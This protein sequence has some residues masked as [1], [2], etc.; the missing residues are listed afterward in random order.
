L[1]GILS[2]EYF[3]K[4]LMIIALNIFTGSLFPLFGQISPGDLTTAH[5]KLEGISNCT[6]C[7]V[8]GEKV[9]NSKCLDCHS[10]I[11]DLMEKGKGFHSGSD[12]K[13]KDCFKC[14]SE[15]NGREFRII[16]FDPKGFDHNKTGYSL[17]GK[18]AEIDCN[19]CHQPKFVSNLN[20]KRIKDTYLG[21]T[22][23]CYTCHEDYHQNTLGNNCGSCHNTISF[24]PAAK[25]D[26]SSAAFRLT[27]AHEKVE[28]IKCHLKEKRNGKDFQVFKGVVFESCESCHHDFH[29]GK[30]G[31][32]CKNCHSTSSFK[33][34]NKK[35]FD[36]NKTN[37]PLGG[38]H[39]DIKCSG[40][41]GSNL[42]SKPK[43]AKCTD[44]HKDAHFGE[45][46]VN[47]IIKDCNDCHSV[48]SF[49][50]TSF[51]IADHSK[52]KFELSGA[53]LAVPC[54]SCHFQEKINQWHFKNIGLSCIDCHHNVHGTEIIEKF[55]PQND[56]TSCHST[57]NWGKISFNHD[58]TNFKLTGKHQTVKCKDCHES[59]TEEDKVQFKF[60]SLKSNCQTCHRDVHFGQFN[61]EQ[62]SDQPVCENCHGFDNWK[63]VKF[64]HEKT[65]F[66][67]KSAHKNLL[68]SSCHKKV[69]ENENVFIKYKLRD[70][71]C[72]SCHS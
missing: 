65:V 39:A 14:H 41:H 1:S 58:L 30:F 59:I 10:E 36:H 26:H 56:C 27:G 49:K 47:K 68:C 5:S 67:L 46:A 44:C 18:H 2:K 15:H 6:K 3:F 20:L 70:F 34:I 55:M 72:A 45:F 23:N 29:K 21:L 52:I 12:V 13:G 32:E 53:H 62:K 66:P 8:L 69:S 37:F 48:E 25:F 43:F 35:E 60:I 17:T 24:K 51:S 31:K 71:K 33:D 22:E 4:A 57:T 28:C 50:I 40:C 11:K 38:A 54:Q 16:N 19:K 9:E 42:N 61:S 7:H 63:P 64:D